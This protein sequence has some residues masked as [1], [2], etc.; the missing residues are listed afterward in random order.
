MHLKLCQ[1]EHSKS[2]HNSSLHAIFVRDQA[3]NL[4][5]I[6]GNE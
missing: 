4:A 3:D 5:V 6:S 1:F 2:E